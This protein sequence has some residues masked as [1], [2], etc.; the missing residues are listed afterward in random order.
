MGSVIVDMYSTWLARR[1]RDDS[2]SK[3]YVREASSR[4]DTARR[5]E[6]SP[7]EGFYFL[8]IIPDP[9]K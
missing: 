7:D 1:A 9:T 8:W 4:N 2:S 3:I 5:K 6:L